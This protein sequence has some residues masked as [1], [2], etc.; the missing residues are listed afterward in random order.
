MSRI[1]CASSL[2]APATATAASCQ[3]FC[4]SSWG[5]GEEPPDHTWKP[6]LWRRGTSRG[7]SLVNRTSGSHLEPVEAHGRGPA[8]QLSMPER[9]REVRTGLLMRLYLPTSPSKRRVGMFALLSRGVPSCPLMLK[10]RPEA[11]GCPHQRD[12]WPPRPIVGMMTFPTCASNHRGALRQ[13]SPGSPGNRSVTLTR[14][15]MALSVKRI[16]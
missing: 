16:I 5:Q 10:V 4:R 8:R 15:K 13:S 12:F 9:K 11:C 1:I 7:G 14:Q 2:V 6:R 3:R